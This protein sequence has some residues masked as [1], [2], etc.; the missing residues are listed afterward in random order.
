LLKHGVTL[1]VVDRADRLPFEAEFLK[2]DL[3][4]VGGIAEA[5][6]AIAAK[7]PDILINLAGIQYFG[8]FEEQTDD[9]I[10]LN[11]TVNLVAPV[12]LTKAVLPG[13]RSRGF[14]QIV[15]I[16]SVFGTIGFAH[17]VTYSS[18]KSGLR[19]FSEALRRELDGTNIGV[20]Y[21]APRAAR[22]GMSNG[23]IMRYAELTS[24]NMDKPEF[25]A[26]RIVAAVR[27]RAK[28]VYIGFPESLFA[29]VNAVMPR[30]VDSAVAKNDR[31]AKSLFGS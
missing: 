12:L 4:T 27:A 6:A 1:S 11:Y 8:L 2:G 17:F 31:K 15:N 25:T 16:G 7:T 19:A 3:S 10:A 29:R 13:M 23:A 20:T 18:A 26:R 22:T 21:V 24:M 14:G 28:D 30:I 5:G 9:H